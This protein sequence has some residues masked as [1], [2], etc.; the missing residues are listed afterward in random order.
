MTM[1][2]NMENH[3]YTIE[4]IRNLY[5]QVQA[6]KVWK[7]YLTNKLISIG[8]TSST[9]DECVFYKEDLICILYTDDSIILSPKMNIINETIKSMKSIG[10]T[11]TV[12][13]SLKEFL[14]VKVEQTIKKNQA[15]E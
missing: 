7:S 10:L 5:G 2:K 12:I 4:L 9:C 11:L 13:G 8:F 15:T 6:G 1:K 3:R 14:G